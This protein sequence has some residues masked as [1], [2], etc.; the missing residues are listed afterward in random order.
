MENAL[1]RAVEK[2]TSPGDVS[3]ELNMNKVACVVLTAFVVL[4]H[5]R[6]GAVALRPDKA[7][8]DSVCDLGPN[9][10]GYLGRKMLVPAVASPKDQIDAYFR[11]A[12]S[13]IATHC[14]D[15]QALILQGS[16]DV[17]VDAPSLT[18][19]ANSACVV[20]SITR[21]DSTIA[22]GDRTMPGFDLRCTIAKHG[23]L[24]QKLAALEQSD[25]MDS[26]KAR[27]IAAVQQA[28]QGSRTSNS[29]TGKKDCGKMTLATLLQ[30]ASC[31]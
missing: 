8:D 3:R 2:Y 30:G 20:A 25:P 21:R 10:N 19:V 5:G 29:G 22:A 18:Q 28:E 9:T 6:A 31:K 11:M 12:S 13:F 14:K 1:P 7:T 15:G 23:E 4:V 24:V 27:M 26:L 16:S 17:S